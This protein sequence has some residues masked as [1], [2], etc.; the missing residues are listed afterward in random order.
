[1]SLES[2]AAKANRRVLPPGGVSQIMPRKAAPHPA[3]RTFAARFCVSIMTS[4]TVSHKLAMPAREARR[5]SGQQNPTI[6]EE[7]PMLSRRLALQSLGALS[8]TALAS[9]AQSEESCAVFTPKTRGT[10]TPDSAL[11][12]LKDG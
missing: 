8:A 4:S 5:Q 2:S 1:M 9:G 10:V 6:S 3:V 7:I 12:M 11:Q